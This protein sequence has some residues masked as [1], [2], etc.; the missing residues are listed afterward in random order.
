MRADDESPLVVPQTR[1]TFHLH[2]QSRAGQRFLESKRTRKVAI[3][4]NG[5]LG[6]S[7]FARTGTPDVPYLSTEMAEES[8]GVSLICSTNFTLCR[9]D[10][11]G[12][13]KNSSNLRTVDTLHCGKW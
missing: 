7:G 1:S 5:H 13:R 12:N 9:T 4:K 6:V 10:C 11:A 3:P 2:G 8:S